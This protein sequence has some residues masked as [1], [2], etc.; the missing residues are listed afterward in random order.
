MAPSEKK[1]PDWFEKLCE[2]YQPDLKADCWA[3]YNREILKN[4]CQGGNMPELDKDKSASFGHCELSPQ[5]TMRKF[6]TGATRNVDN[7]KL[8]YEGFLSPLVLERFAVYLNKHRVQADGQVRDSD[9][10]TRGIP[11]DVYMKSLL[12]HVVDLWKT[13]RGYP[14]PESLEDNLC[15]AMFNIQGYLFEV[16]SETNPRRSAKTL[17]GEVAQ[18]KQSK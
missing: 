17:S 5:E 2:G 9:N 14:T 18:T 16:L 12:R 15:A 7:N 6:E 11:K 1:Y 10:W 4:E 8:D 13:H 3:T